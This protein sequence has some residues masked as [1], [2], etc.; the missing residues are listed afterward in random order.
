L[1]EGDLVVVGNRTGLQAGEKVE[2][3]LVQLSMSNEN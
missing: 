2:P 3:T 1:Q